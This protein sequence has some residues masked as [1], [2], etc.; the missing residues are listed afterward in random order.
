[1]AVAPIVNTGKSTA[2][3]Q[4]VRSKVLPSQNNH[5]EKAIR[6]KSDAK[7]AKRCRVARVDPIPAISGLGESVVI[8]VS[9]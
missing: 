8:M 6:M 5:S 7:S 9:T 2:I 3:H 4:G 1:L